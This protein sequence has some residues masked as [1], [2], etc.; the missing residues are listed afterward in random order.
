MAKD[1]LYFQED[2]IIACTEYAAKFFG[3][4]AA[5]L[6]N[7]AKQGCP[8]VGYGLWDVRAVTDYLQKKQ[9]VKVDSF[10][11]GNP[12]KMSPASA[13]IFYESKLKEAQLESTNFR[14]AI[15][16]GDYLERSFVVSSLSEFCIILKRS[17]VGV[18]KK[19]S[20]EISPYVE[21]DMA[22]VISKDIDDSL[23][24]VLEQLSV[25]GVYR[26]EG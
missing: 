17:L 19:L 16:R 13:K 20:R 1:K 7:W 26:F 6:S 4:S 11:E 12:E 9:G 14:N 23:I 15:N 25:D 8:Q 18:G 22:R 10:L 21:P 2:T 3:V 24:D 5:T